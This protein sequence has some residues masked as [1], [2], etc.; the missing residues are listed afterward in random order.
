MGNFLDCVKSRRKPIGD[1]T[2]GASSVIVC[3]IGVIALRAGKQLK[4]DPAAHRF[5]DAEANRM[6]GRPTRPPWKLDV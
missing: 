1:A 5:D 2:V 4:W 6:L 3:P